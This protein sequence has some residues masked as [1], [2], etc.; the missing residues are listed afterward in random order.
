MPLNGALPSEK[1]AAMTADDDSRTANP[2]AAGP[3]QAVVEVDA[4]GLQCPLPLLKA[5]Q[6]LNTLA[7]GGLLR[8]RSTDAGSV[9]DFEVFARQTGHALLEASSADGTFA[10][11]LRKA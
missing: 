3:E 4:R 9:R 11:L 10:F 7:S 6:A 2:G 1:P 8:V 5:K